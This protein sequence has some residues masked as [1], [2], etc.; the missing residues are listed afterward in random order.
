MTDSLTETRRKWILKVC[1]FEIEERLDIAEEFIRGSYHLGLRKKSWQ[2]AFSGFAAYRE[3]YPDH[4]RQAIRQWIVAANYANG[5]NVSARIER[6][7]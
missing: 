1:I 3:D 2:E 7:M 5:S 6:D 4:Q